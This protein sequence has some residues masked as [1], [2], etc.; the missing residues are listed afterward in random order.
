LK[1]GWFTKILPQSFNRTNYKSYASLW[2]PF[3]KQRHIALQQYAIIV[4]IIW[5]KYTKKVVSSVFI[6]GRR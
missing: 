3:Q 1:I 6:A 4:K 5:Q 2:I